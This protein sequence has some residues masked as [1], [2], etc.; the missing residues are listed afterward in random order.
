MTEVARPTIAMVLAAGRGERMR[1]LTDT[2]PK[3]LLEVGGT[4]LLERHL[5]RLAAA[6]VAT[7]VINLG[8][9]GEAIVER[10]G[11]GRRYGLRVVYSPEYDGVLETG[12]GIRRALPMLGRDPFWVLNAD[13]HTDFALPPVE[14]APASLGHLVL[15]PTPAHK[16]RGDFDLVA[17][18]A[19]VSDAPAYTFSGMA[20]YRPA[21]FEG[22]APGRFPLA[23][24]LFDAAGRGLL[25][26]SLYEGPWVDVGTPER[27]AALQ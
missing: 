19:A 15:V 2:V 14:L 8:W 17:G 20:L 5:A 13:V 11:D 16:T 9:L 27:L 6:G 26:A 7:V 10:V 4:S 25:E 12:G 22:T 23:P 24:L 18:K 1:P 21:L 3:A